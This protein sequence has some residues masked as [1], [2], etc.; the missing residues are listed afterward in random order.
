MQEVHLIA[1]LS[2][3]WSLSSSSRPLYCDVIQF[4]C[5]ALYLFPVFT[6]LFL[7]EFLK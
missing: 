1:I 5:V 3:K 7:K 2:S 6:H 4:L